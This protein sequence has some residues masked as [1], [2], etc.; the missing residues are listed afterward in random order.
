M[1]MIYFI[2]YVFDQFNLNTETTDVIFKWIIDKKS[3]TYLKLKEFITHLKFDKLPEEFSYSY[4]FNQI[5]HHFFINLFNLQLC[6]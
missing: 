4:T 5:P 2:M 3:S 1:D 6:E